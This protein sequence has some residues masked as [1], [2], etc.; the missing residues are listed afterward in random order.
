MFFFWKRF[1]SCLHH[2]DQAIVP[3]TMFLEDDGFAIVKL[4]RFKAN[5]KIPVEGIPHPIEI[6]RTSIAQGQEG[7]AILVETY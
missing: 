7:S 3:V 4:M 6:T 2:L 1:Y 5:L